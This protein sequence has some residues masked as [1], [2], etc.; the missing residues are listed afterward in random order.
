MS[1][2]KAKA[3][4]TVCAALLV[5]RTRLHLLWLIGA[6]AQAGALGWV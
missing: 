3:L 6:G 2:P 5:W 4:L 1:V